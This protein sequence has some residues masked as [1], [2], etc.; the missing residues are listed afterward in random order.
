MQAFTFH[1]VASSGTS[2]SVYLPN[3]TG[4]TGATCWKIKSITIGNTV[5]PVTTNNA[6]V[7]INNRDITSGTIVL[8]SQATAASGHGAHW[9]FPDGLTCWANGDFAVCT[10]EYNTNA[11]VALTLTQ[12]TTLTV[13]AYPDQG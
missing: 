12:P 2:L 13:T 5:C 7:T 1:T 8:H 4:A 6:T 3:R 11:D 9:T 10:L